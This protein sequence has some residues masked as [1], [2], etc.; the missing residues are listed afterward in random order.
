MSSPVPVLAVDGIHT[1]YGDSHILQGVSL[2]AKRD[3]VI[4]ALPTPLSRQYA[5]PSL[6]A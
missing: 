5:M 2:R 6:N 3:A 4:I 1:Y